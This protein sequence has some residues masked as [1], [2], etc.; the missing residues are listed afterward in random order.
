MFMIETYI[1]LSIIMSY[2]LLRDVYERISAGEFIIKTKSK[3]ISV[4]YVVLL[5]LCACITSFEIVYY[6]NNKKI[7]INQIL[8]GI[9]WIQIFILNLLSNR[10]LGLTEGGIYSGDLKSSYFTKWN[11]IRSYKWISDNVIQFEVLEKK[12]KLLIRI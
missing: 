5:I 9:F 1:I 11:R 3:K 4:L 7:N 8:Q 10:S 6:L 12:I 2:C